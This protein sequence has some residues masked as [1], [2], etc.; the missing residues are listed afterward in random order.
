[1]ILVRTSF[2]SLYTSTTGVLEYTPYD[3]T[4]YVEQSELNSEIQAANDHANTIVAA[5]AQIRANADE[6]LLNLHQY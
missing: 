6:D 2:I 4:N 5:E 3:L 1:M